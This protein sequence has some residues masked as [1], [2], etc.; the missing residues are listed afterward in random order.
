MCLAPFSIIAVSWLFSSQIFFIVM[1][2]MRK[3][4][5]MLRNTYFQRVFKIM[6]TFPSLYPMSNKNCPAVFQLLCSDRG[7]HWALPVHIPRSLIKIEDAT[8]NFKQRF[9]T[10]SSSQSFTTVRITAGECLCLQHRLVA[11]W[12][13]LTFWAERHPDYGGRILAPPAQS[14][15]IMAK[16]MYLRSPQTCALKVTAGKQFRFQP[17]GFPITATGLSCSK[18]LWSQTKTVQT[19]RSDVATITNMYEC[20]DCHLYCWAIQFLS[21]I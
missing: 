7:K 10:L 20:C 15:Q 19:L 2:P 17:G 13:T 6:C 18:N 8:E 3:S 14:I 16:G 1:Q 5:D 4:R 21:K 12:N 9:Y 11:I